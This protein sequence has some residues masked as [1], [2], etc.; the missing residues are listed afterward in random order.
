MIA[1]IAILAAILFP[2]FMS[3]R[4]AARTSQC[5]SNLHQMAVATLTYADDYQGTFP[6]AWYPVNTYLTIK[7]KTPST[8]DTRCWRDLVFKYVKSWNCQVC[9]ERQT[10]IA[11]G[12]IKVM[13][14]AKAGLGIL[15][16]SYGINQ[17]L[18][19]TKESPSHGVSDRPSRKIGEVRLASKALM[20]ADWGRSGYDEVAIPLDDGGFA[21]RPQGLTFTNDWL[22]YDRLAYNIHSGG[23]NIAFVDG[24]VKHYKFD[25]WAK[26]SGALLKGIYG[27]SAQARRSS[28]Y[29]E[30][31]DLGAIYLW[32]PNLPPVP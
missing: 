7:G 21:G 8:L 17:V 11:T 22:G 23:G 5:G 12:N 9:V 28:E 4:S 29:R 6:L 1:I 15:T 25:R 24:H 18:A 20:I 3:A 19:G 26:V 27:G 10:D 2:V 31:W 30:G 13:E 32:S 16:A 14:A